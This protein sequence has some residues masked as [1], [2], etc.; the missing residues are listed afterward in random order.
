MSTKTSFLLNYKHVLLILF[1]VLA[2]NWFFTFQLVCLKDDNSFYY[3]PVRMYLSDALH[4]G[5]LPFWNPYLL[6]GIPQYADM[7][8]A[9]WNPIAFTLCY[10][11]KYNH[12]LFLI[13][14]LIYIFVA[15]IGVYKLLS[16]VTNHFQLILLGVIV[17]IG[18]GFVSGIANFINWTASLAFI[19]WIFFLFFSLLQKPSL[20]KA[21]VLGI[22]G[23]LMLVCAYPAFIIYTAYIL[24]VIILFFAVQHIQQKIFS[25]FVSKVLFLVLALVIALLLSLPAILSY[26]EFLPFYSRGKDL[27]TDLPFRD[28]FYPQFLSSLFVPSSIYNKNYDILCHS[29]NRDIYFGVAPLMILVLFVQ[30]YKKHTTAFVT[31]LTVIAIST[32]IFLFGFLTPLGSFSFNNLPLM[33]SFKWS[34]AA[35]IY[36]LMLFIVAIVYQ[37]KQQQFIQPTQQKLIRVFCVSMLIGIIVVFYFTQ[38]SAVFE[39][40]LHKKVF[41]ANTVLQFMLWLMVFFKMKHLLSNTKKLLLFVL[42]DIILNYSIG[43]AM[44]GIGNV[45]PK[46]FN[47]YAAEF[48]KQEP[49]EYLKHPLA[50]NRTIYMFNPWKNHNASKIM[51][52][53]TFLMSNT[54]FSGY[55]QLFIQ[56]TANE[57]ILRNHA[58][59]FSED[60][61]TLK[62]HSVNLTYSSIQVNVDCNKAGS[63]ILQQNNYYRWK[64]M[65][66]LPINTWRNCFM[67]IPVKAGNNKINLKY[68][69]GSY[70]LLMQ[71]S[72][73][74]LCL[75]IL[76]LLFS[77]RYKIL[78][79]NRQPR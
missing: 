50:L 46:V 67:Q 53:A 33:G 56:D 69:K 45:P 11:F 59:A 72:Y 68:I 3:M 23:W 22:A 42:I 71:L 54:I 51:N 66:G 64:E 19:P 61:D 10:F 63:I 78:P 75:L 32:F 20:K 58:F 12:S 37:L 44:T 9:V 60:I 47:N 40:S 52:G 25:L 34:A 4:S 17:Y 70:S 15:A 26:A 8:G 5:G 36:L 48:Y 41:Y 77:S 39:T 2:A 28:C 76:V 35:R 24:L 55:E 43:M 27:A 18:S 73:T 6:N 62:I 38:Q 65:S 21:I 31:L 49:N 30:Q 7:Q 16:L 57:S 1:L 13:E 74:F 29:A 14:Y 79:T